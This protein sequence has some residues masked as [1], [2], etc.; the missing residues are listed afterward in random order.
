MQLQDLADLPLD[1][2]ERL[3]EVIG[4]WNTMVMSSPRTLRISSSSAAIRSLPLNRI[5]A[6]RVMRG[7]VGQELEYREGGDG[8]AGARLAHQ[9]HRLAWHDVEGDA[10]DRQHVA[11][12]LAEGDGE[13]LD[14][15]EGFW[16]WPSVVIANVIQ[17]DLR[18]A[19]HGSLKR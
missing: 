1:G 12:A 17:A 4:S 5:A 2:V 16:S 11:S 13:V 3:S 6:G 7:R 19:A 15:E 9:R 10:V 14:G 8:L 18:Q